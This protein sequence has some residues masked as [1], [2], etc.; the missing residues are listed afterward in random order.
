MR[1]IKIMMDGYQYKKFQK[2]K[3]LMKNQIKIKLKN[4]IFKKKVNNIF[5]IEVIKFMQKCQQK[6]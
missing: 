5:L 4:P 1:L 3:I 6:V 2:K